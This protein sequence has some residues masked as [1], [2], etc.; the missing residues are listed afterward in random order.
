MGLIEDREEQGRKEGGIQPSATNVTI[1]TGI[2]AFLGVL[3]TTIPGL[4]DKLFGKSVN[5]EVRKDVI[6]AILFAWAIVAASDLIA[7]AIGKA[8]AE[9]TKAAAESSTAAGAP[10]ELPAPAGM[11]VTVTKGTV[12]PGWLVAAMRVEPGTD[13]LSYLVVKKQQAAKWV[14]AADVI[15]TSA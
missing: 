11:R 13:K 4:I 6:V 8:A 10:R 9:R 14:D 7:R 2:V 12:D 15:V 3:T 1:G 5:N